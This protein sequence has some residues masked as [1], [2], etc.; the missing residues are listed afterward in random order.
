MVDDD[1]EDEE[2]EERELQ[3]QPQQRDEPL[4]ITTPRAPVSVDVWGAGDFETLV[5]QAPPLSH[6]PLPQASGSTLPALFTQSLSHAPPVMAPPVGVSN[7][8]MFPPSVNPYA[9][10]TRLVLMAISAKTKFLCSIIS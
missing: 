1:S 5:N 3:L 8:S 7:Q 6:S 10:N 9:I 2:Q 4:T